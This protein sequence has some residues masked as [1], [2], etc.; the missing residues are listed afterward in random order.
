VNLPLKPFSTA[1]LTALALGEAHAYAIEQQMINDV[2]GAILIKSW[3]VYR[4]LPRLV[5]AKLIDPVPETRPG[6]YRL[7]KFGRTILLSERANAERT[8]KL[9]QA[10]L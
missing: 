8:L 10:R 6:R 3:A 5:Q 2:Q 1:L 7:T 4:E 9:L